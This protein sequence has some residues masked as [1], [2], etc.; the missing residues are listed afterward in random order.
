[1][2]AEQDMRA[3]DR[4]R[5]HTAAA[6]RARIDRETEAWIGRHGSHR[7]PSPPPSPPLRGGEG[8]SVITDVLPWLRGGVLLWHAAIGWCPPLPVF[9][10]LGFRTEREILAE[11]ETLARRLTQASEAVL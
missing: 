11:R 5:S 8:A 1:M 10:R 9:R 2:E 3:A 6:V 7:A 4:V